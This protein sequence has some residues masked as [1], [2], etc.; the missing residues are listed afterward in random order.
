MN[1]VGGSVLM[2][3]VIHSPS[4]LEAQLMVWARGKDSELKVHTENSEGGKQGKQ[5]GS[6]LLKESKLPQTLRTG[7]F[8]KYILKA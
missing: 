8:K 3:S 6:L 1:A 7:L 5:S 4:G 2:E